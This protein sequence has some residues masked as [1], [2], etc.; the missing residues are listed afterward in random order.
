[1]SYDCFKEWGIRAGG[2]YIDKFNTD[3]V[4]GNLGGSYWLSSQT[5][6]ALDAE[7]TPNPTVFPIQAY[8]G[9]MSQVIYD[10]WVPELSY[11]FAQYAAVHTHQVIPALSWYFVRGFDWVVRYYLTV[12]QSGRPTAVT[13]SVMTRLNWS[14][15]E[16]VVLY[17]GYARENA[18]FDS[19]NP[20]LIGGYAANH[21]LAGF[22]WESMQG[23]GAGF[24]FD[25]EGRDNATNLQSYEFVVFLRF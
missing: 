9:S 21:Y 20:L 14:P 17:A 18:W 3:A 22:Q 10:N 2:H 7:F 19:G 1:M 6:F 4:G 11:R 23:I 25:H 13:H 5:A 16:P 12:Y 24:N 15:I 8:T